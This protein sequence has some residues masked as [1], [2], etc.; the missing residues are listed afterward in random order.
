MT[1]TSPASTSLTAGWEE[2]YQKAMA[3]HGAVD[4]IC[5]A[6]ARLSLSSALARCQALPVDRGVLRVYGDVSRYH[7]LWRRVQGPHRTARGA[8]MSELIADSAHGRTDG[9]AR[10]LHSHH[11]AALRVGLPR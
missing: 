5:P 8:A 1:S 6:T 10:R 2:R 4:L 9:A 11:G 3:E 7:P